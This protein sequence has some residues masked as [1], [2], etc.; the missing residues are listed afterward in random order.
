M[1]DFH[2]HILPNVDDG[3]KSMERTLNMLEEAKEVGF[4]HIISTS[5]YMEDYYEHTEEERKNIL[6]EIF[7][8]T[9][10]LKLYLG[11]EVYFSENIINLLEEKKASTINGSRYVLFE[12]SLS[13]KPIM[14]KDI[15]YRLI[16]H[17]YIPI[18]AHPERYSFVQDDIDFIYDLVDMGALLQANYGSIVGMYG[19]KAQK[20]LKKLLKED[21]I[22]FLG[23]DVHRPDQIYPLI[24]K[25]IKKIKKY[26]SEER[27]E[28][29]STINAQ[30]VL[31]DE[32][33]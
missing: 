28:E 18:I 30:K 13:S 5:H 14:A 10:G 1:I 7:Q 15:V 33:I 2:S 20:T 8:K 19:K 16:D 31:N 12:F 25:A 26:I 29:L 11:S 32:E 6:D 21:V 27:F 9:E 3:S 22:S 24:P 4:T 17:N 23:S